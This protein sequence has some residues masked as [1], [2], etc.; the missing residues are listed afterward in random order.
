MNVFG[1]FP[2]NVGS[3]NFTITKVLSIEAILLYFVEKFS[4][5]SDLS[6][7][8][9]EQWIIHLIFSSLQLFDFL[10]NNF[11]ILRNFVVDFRKPF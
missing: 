4:S 5:N 3:K 8:E 11:E 7:E 1:K 2:E 9:S 10:G 6:F